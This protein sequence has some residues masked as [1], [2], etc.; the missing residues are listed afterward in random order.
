MSTVD[1]AYELLRRGD[2]AAAFGALERAMA[3]GDSASAI[4]LAA[5][6][7]E[8]RYIARDL[9][10]SRAYFRRAGELGDLSAE[11]IYISFLANGV[12]GSSDWAGAVRRLRQLANVDV[13]AARQLALIDAMD[14]ND[15]GD[16][17]RPSTGRN[18]SSRPAAL[19]F[20]AFLTSSECRY[21][22]DA[23][24]PLLEPSVIVDPATGQ[25]RPHPIRTSEG[26]AFPLVSED[27][28][29]SALNRRMAVASG[30]A[31][32]CGEPLQVLRYQ[33]GQEYRP[34]FDALPSGD[35][36]RV[37]T[38]LLYL[39]ADF[40]GG[41][42]LF[43]ET[44]LRFRGALGDAL[45]FRNARPDGSPDPMSKHAGLPVSDGQKYLA[46]RWIRE[47]PLLVG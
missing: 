30:T 5:L 9:Q 28:V 31:Y 37:L 24:A 40:S 23:A 20:D 22:I 2:P 44:G 35:N 16:P 17:N 47:R 39:N 38:M 25:L 6:F 19:V 45:L 46:T 15:A 1:H 3:A 41:E 42:T 18:L 43:T 14:L 10:R 33:P 27:L 21:L 26:A 7:L 8:G 13:L 29:V 12:G 11:K 4:E 32:A 34:H 36:Q